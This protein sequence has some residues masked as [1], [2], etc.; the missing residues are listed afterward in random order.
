MVAGATAATAVVYDIFMTTSDNNWKLTGPEDKD[1]VRQ[2]L[3][4]LLSHRVFKAS[5]RSLK[6]LRYIVNSSLEESRDQLK[7]RIVGIEVFERDTGYDTSLDPIVRN[8]AA[9]LRKRIAQYYH[10]G[11]HEGEIRIDLPPGSYVPTFL[12]PAARQEEIQ[13]ST[14]PGIPLPP[15]A[16]AP[17]PWKRRL[18][19]VAG[20]T[21][22]FLIATLG[23]LEFRPQSARDRFWKPLLDS[24][25]SVMLFVG[26]TPSATICNSGT[27][28]EA[29]D[30][31]GVAGQIIRYLDRKDK[32]FDLRPTKEANLGDMRLGP[33]VILSVFDDSWTIRK[34]QPLRFHFATDSGSSVWIE[35]ATRPSFKEWLVNI[36]TPNAKRSRDYGIVARFIDEATRRPLIVASGIGEGGAFAAAEFLTSTSQVEELVK[37]APKDWNQ[38]NIEVVVTTQI[39]DGKAGAPA[40]AAAHYW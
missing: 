1:A 20:A 9:D 39:V 18:W 6:L 4:R 8:A 16:P 14:D 3:E 19:M 26:G 40:I 22:I 13:R 7:E 37:R 27:P 30:M 32:T 11:E 33:V 38:K 10:E 5:P 15:A 17:R 25:D 2:Q 29:A 24:A 23:W 28:R 34:I 21:G 36:D 35:D 31:V 12:L